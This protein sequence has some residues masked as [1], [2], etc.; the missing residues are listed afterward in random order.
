MDHA[1]GALLIDTGAVGAPIGLGHQLLERGRIALVQKIARALPAED[2]S[3][4]RPPWGAAVRL[5]PGE[6]IEEHCR[7]AEAPLGAAFALLAAPEHVAKQVLRGLAVEEVLLV[8]RALV[9]VSGR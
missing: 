5:I 3:G 2:V 1:V 4:R 9:G 7:L 8:R 6:E